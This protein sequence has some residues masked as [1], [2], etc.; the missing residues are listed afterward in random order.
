MQTFKKERERTNSTLFEDDMTIMAQSQS[1]QHTDPSELG[2]QLVQ[3]IESS[4]QL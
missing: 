4:Y 3:K 2:P 1:P